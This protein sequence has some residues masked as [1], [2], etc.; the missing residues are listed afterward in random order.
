MQNVQ[1]EKDEHIAMIKLNRGVTN[2]LGPEII[3]E[4]DQ[5][6]HDIEKDDEVR[7]IVLHSN[8]D[9][10]FSI[11]LDL[12]F[13][14]ELHRSEL[15]TFMDDFNKLCVKLYTIPVP[16]VAA[17]TGHAIAGGCIIAL[18]CDHRFI[19]DGRKL[20]GLNEVRL[21]LPVPYPADVMLRHELGTRTA[22]VIMETG[23]LYPPRDSLAFG[24]VDAIYPVDEVRTRAIELAKEMGM[25]SLEAF[26]M[27]KRNRVEPVEEE[28]K[29]HLRSREKYF[30][31]LWNTE[32]TLEKLRE[33]IKKF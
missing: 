17:I 16:T 20:M 28:V 32:P 33:A 10:F 14:I 15:Q 29:H 25:Y 24:M 5:I 21:G 19:A 27:I 11:G 26:E 4:M 13:L 23:K 9:K 3:N 7:G 18:C 1:L 31:K 30:C 22:R 8:N 2:A 12:P 6:M